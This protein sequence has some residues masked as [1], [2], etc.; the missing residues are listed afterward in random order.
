VGKSSVTDIPYIPYC[1]YP[2]SLFSSFVTVPTRSARSY[3]F[4]KTLRF[5]ISHH[6]SYSSLAF[7]LVTCNLLTQFISLHLSYKRVFV[8]ILILDFLASAIANKSFMTS[9][10]ELSCYAWWNFACSWNRSNQAGFLYQAGHGVQRA[11]QIAKFT[12][13]DCMTSWECSART[14]PAVTIPQQSRCQ[15]Y[16][17]ECVNWLLYSF[18]STIAFSSFE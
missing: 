4:L 12:S 14:V 5:H 6:V 16:T 17:L 9:C 18:L 10:Q 2:V 3:S 15:S 13:A 7:L 8:L 1:T 11:N